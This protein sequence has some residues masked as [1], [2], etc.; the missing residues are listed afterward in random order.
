MFSFRQIA[1]V[2]SLA[3]PCAGFAEG[4]NLGEHITN[5]DV[6]SLVIWPDGGGLPPGSGTVAEGQATYTQHCL[7]CHGPQGK[8]GIN[9]TLVG[10]Q[11]HLTEIPSI[12]TVGSYWPYTT[13]LFDY[14]RRAMPYN[15]PGSLSN[16][17]VY[18]VVAYLLHL[19]GL[20]DDDTQ[21]NAQRLTEI[22][23]PNRERFFSRYELP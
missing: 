1:I 15:E 21:L 14:V 8:A 2:I 6:S 12:R 13:S 4:P 5:D 16:K 3:L 11:V 10:G 19:N 7:I 9:D 23:L 17:Q 20:I 22:K 18:G